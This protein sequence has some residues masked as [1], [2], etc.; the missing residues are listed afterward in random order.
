MTARIRSVDNADTLLEEYG[1][2]SPFLARK[3]DFKVL[4]IRRGLA[5]AEAAAVK[6]PLNSMLEANGTITLKG[7]LRE[8]D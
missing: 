5:L 7:M 8:R 6:M 2:C 1:G 3:A 4:P